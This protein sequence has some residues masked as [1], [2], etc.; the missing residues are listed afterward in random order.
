MM[1]LNEL[2]DLNVPTPWGMEDDR[3]GYSLLY[4]FLIVGLLVT[5]GTLLML[6][7]A[8]KG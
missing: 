1:I 8:K 2:A 5:V 7:K 4:I 6:G 3:E